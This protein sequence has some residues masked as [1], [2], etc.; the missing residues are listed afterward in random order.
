MRWYILGKHSSSVYTTNRNTEDSINENSLLCLSDIDEGE[1]SILTAEV[2]N[3]S[4]I[5]KKGSTTYEEII[6]FNQHTKLLNSFELEVRVTILFTSLC[7][8]TLLI[9]LNFK[10][11]TDD[12]NHAND[13]TEDNLIYIAGSV[14]KKFKIKYSYLEDTTEY[15]TEQQ[16]DWMSYISKGFS[17]FY[18]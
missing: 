3:E 10:K 6:K 9:I 17:S 11:S 5:L 8:Q 13:Y 1:E 2:I 15:C 14:A 7:W 4:K 18:Y 16:D 12:A